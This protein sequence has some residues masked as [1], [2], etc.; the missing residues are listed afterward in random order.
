MEI[1][2]K[3]IVKHRISHEKKCVVWLIKHLEW[4]NV[5]SRNPN[6]LAQLVSVYFNNYKRILSEF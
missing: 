3:I 1:N 6:G 4:V 5:T 2:P